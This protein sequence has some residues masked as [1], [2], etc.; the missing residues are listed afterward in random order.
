M[1]AIKQTFIVIWFT[2]VHGQYC[3]MFQDLYEIFYF[4]HSFRFLIFI[5]LDELHCLVHIRRGFSSMN[6]FIEKYF[7]DHS[8]IFLVCAFKHTFTYQFQIHFKLMLNIKV[9]FFSNLAVP[10]IKNK[11]W[12]YTILWL[13]LQVLSRRGHYDNKDWNKIITL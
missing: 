12:M 10:L 11:S 9:I 3:D 7:I 1:V 6:Y 8:K 5:D 13:L 2:I 4:I